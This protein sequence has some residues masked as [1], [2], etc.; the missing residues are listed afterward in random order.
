MNPNNRNSCLFATPF[1]FMF[2]IGFGKWEN[3]LIRRQRIIHLK[4]ILHFF[5]EELRH[6]NDPV[7]FRCFG[8]SYNVLLFHPVV[9]FIDLH[10]LFLKIKI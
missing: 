7:T 10:G 9:R 3:P 2:Q 1:H 4:I 6:Y 5:T 8:R